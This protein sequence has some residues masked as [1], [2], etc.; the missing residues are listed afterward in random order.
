[1]NRFYRITLAAALACALT[2]CL[3]SCLNRT[4]KTSENQE[5]TTEETI[6]EPVF[7]PGDQV[8]DEWLLKR[9]ASSFFSVSPRSDERRV[10]KEC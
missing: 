2:L 9:G 5:E 1:M 4:V 6:A 3:N 8:P 7:G 10:G